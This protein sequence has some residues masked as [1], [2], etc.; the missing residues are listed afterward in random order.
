MLDCKN[1]KKYNEFGGKE[2]VYHIFPILC[3]EREKLQA[4]LKENDVPIKTI[5]IDSANEFVYQSPPRAEKVETM[6]PR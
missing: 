2:Y 6:I 4:Y 5:I 3:N 1:I